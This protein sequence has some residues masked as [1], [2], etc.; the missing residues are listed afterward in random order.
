MHKPLAGK[1]PVV[2]LTALIGIGIIALIV[3]MLIGI[4]SGALIW[5]P[6]FTSSML[7]SGQ[8]TQ[9]VA[10]LKYMQLLSHL[11]MFV[12]PALIFAKLTAGNVHS[13]FCGRNKN[14]FLLVFTAIAMLVSSFPLI[15]LLTGWNATFTLPESLAST[16]DW[17]RRTEDEATAITT[18]FMKTTSVE[19]LI[20]NLLLL[21]VIP[22]LGEELIFRGILQKVLIRWFRS[23]LAGWVV[24]AIIFSAI[25]MQFYGFLPRLWLGLLLGYMVLRS[26]K[27]LPAILVHFANNGFMVLSYYLFENGWIS[28]NPESI[29]NYNEDLPMLALSF[30]VLGLSVVLFTRLS[31]RLKPVND[32]GDNTRTHE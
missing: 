29:G 28:I 6:D 24:T 22:A 19:G 13:F 7:H 5:G 12:F 16:E 17:M 10:Y 3:V 20:V 14:T 25:H 2:Q 26:G 31:G 4:L 1:H 15:N 8:Q 23:G 18:L 9:N 32:M 30:F 27:L 21:A 11:G